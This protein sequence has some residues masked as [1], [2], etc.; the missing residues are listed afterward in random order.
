MLEVEEGA[1]VICPLEDEIIGPFVTG[2]GDDEAP[3][4]GGLWAITRVV[5]GL[6][7]EDRVVLGDWVEIMD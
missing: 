1:E 5:L 4:D 2:G 6:V 7:L 3:V